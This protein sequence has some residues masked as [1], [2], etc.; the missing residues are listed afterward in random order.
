MENIPSLHLW[1]DPRLLAIE[2]VLPIR[3]GNY[4]E[5]EGHKKRHPEEYNLDFLK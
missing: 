5:G 4:Y 1:D 2:K 3:L